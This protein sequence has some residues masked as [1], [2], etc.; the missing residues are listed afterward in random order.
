[1]A[2]F[3]KMIEICGGEI[4]HNP[5]EEWNEVCTVTQTLTDWR[6]TWRRSRM[7]Y[8]GNH[9][10]T[11]CVHCHGDQIWRIFGIQLIDRERVRQ[12]AYS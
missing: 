2:T 8:V 12:A 10:V 11:C 4:G 7:K 1:M 9:D 3:E 5:L 6:K